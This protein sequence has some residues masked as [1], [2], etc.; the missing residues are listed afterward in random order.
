MLRHLPVFALCAR[1]RSQLDIVNPV[2]DRAFHVQCR[3]A[4]QRQQ[5]TRRFL[6]DA[7]LQCFIVKPACLRK[8]VTL[9]R[10]EPIHSFLRQVGMRGLPVLGVLAP[11]LDFFNLGDGGIPLAE[12]LKMKAAV[13]D[14]LC[15][16]TAGR[17]NFNAQVSH[18]KNGPVG[19]PNTELEQ[20][21]HIGVFLILR[22]THP[23][24]ISHDP[25]GLRSYPDQFTIHRE[26]FAVRSGPIVPYATLFVGQWSRGIAGYSRPGFDVFGDHRRSAG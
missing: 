17:L 26:S 20:F 14:Y 8:V 19:M 16:D 6:S 15:A 3:R 5:K 1:M 21:F 7:F 18:F 11:R 25:F 23:S 12:L 24:T 9:R 2:A 13:P 4:C 10:L 22:I